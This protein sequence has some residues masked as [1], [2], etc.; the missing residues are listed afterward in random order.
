MTPLIRSAT[1]SDLAELVGLLGQLG[2]P[3]AADQLALRLQRIA[4]HQ[5]HV[6]L[7][8]EAPA[9]LSGL[10]H[11]QRIDLLASDGYAEVQA[12]V[13]D[14]AHR[15]QGLGRALLQEAARQAGALGASRL[16]LRSGLHREEAHRFYI[17][18]GYE[19]CRASYA[20]ERL[21]EI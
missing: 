4:Q 8:S 3:C 5:D 2:Y 20:F 7:V 6:L 17:A 12:L 14:A 19:Q 21:V 15:R 10:C 9:G 16:R 18:Q 1:A 13:V 11:F